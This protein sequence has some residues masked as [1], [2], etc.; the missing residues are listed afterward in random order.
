MKKL[1]VP[2]LLI[3]VLGACSA[4]RNFNSEFDFGNKLAQEGL[5]KEAH[6]RW[7]K[8]LAEGKR[9]AALYNNLA[10]A[11]EEMGEFEKAEEAYKKAL[12]LSP[13]NLTIQSNL[14]KLKKFLTKDTDEKKSKKDE[15]EDEE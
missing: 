6:F 1:L 3:T 14:N 4:K 8:A 11:L 15:Q 7:K 9:S 2:L 10:V 13:N 5:W 12:K